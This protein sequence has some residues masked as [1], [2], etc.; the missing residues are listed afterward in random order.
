MT[1]ILII[2]GLVLLALGGELL[3]RGAVGIANL[4]RVSP[5]LTGL[6]IVGF[7]TSMPELVTGIEAALAGA[8][9]IAVGNVVGSNIANILLI[10]GVTAVIVPLAIDPRAFR[11]DGLA[12]VAST[13]AVVAFA[14]LGE[15]G[16]VAG[17]FLLAVL[18]AYLVWAYLGERRSPDE[19][20]EMLEHIAQ[21]AAPKTR[22]WPLLAAMAVGGI[23]AA[24]FGAQFLVEGAIVLAREWGVSEAVIGL[25]VVAIGTSLPELIACSVAALRRH[26][27]V[28]LGNV[29]GSNI[30]NVFGILGATA[31]V[32]PLAV[33]PEIAALDAWVLLGVTAL[34][35]LFLRTGWTLKRWEGAVFVA[36]YVAY[37]TWLFVGGSIAQA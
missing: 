3:V 2:G 30:Y 27:D 9:G 7:G 25:S 15:I 22:S 13:L 6:T 36:L 12:V 31:V 16:L 10:L 17:L 33:P 20:G 34:L 26:A 35:I 18:V 28:A 37:C 24:I 19:E 14:L 21:D 29:V 32:K 11:R 8:P 23:A 5:L 4:L 1:A